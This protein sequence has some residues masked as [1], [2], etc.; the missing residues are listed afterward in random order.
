MSERRGW[1]G[2]KEEGKTLSDDG[3]EKRCLFFNRINTPPVL[4]SRKLKRAP[5]KNRTNLST[6]ARRSELFRAASLPPPWEET[7]KR[8]SE[9]LLPQATMPPPLHD[10]EERSTDVR[11]VVVPV[12]LLLPLM[13]MDWLAGDDAHS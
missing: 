6:R 7:R 5:A 12:L 3:Q 11:P 8:W 13:R 4:L 10:D 2:G 1:G 9:P